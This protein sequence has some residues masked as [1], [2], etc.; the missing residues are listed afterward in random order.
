MAHEEPR[1]NPPVKKPS[2]VGTDCAKCNSC[3]SHEV[4]LEDSMSIVCV[5]LWTTFGHGR[6]GVRDV[7]DHSLVQP[8]SLALF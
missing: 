6:A 3:P 1:M 5:S 7:L 4:R 2:C 8:V